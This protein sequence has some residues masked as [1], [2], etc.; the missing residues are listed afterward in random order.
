MWLLQLILLQGVRECAISTRT[1]CWLSNVRIRAKQLFI[2]GFVVPAKPAGRSSSRW[3][4]LQT[5]LPSRHLPAAD[6]VP[7]LLATST[8]PPKGQTLGPCMVDPPSATFQL[9]YLVAL[10]YAQQPVPIWAG[11]SQYHLTSTAF[12]FRSSPTINK[13]DLLLFWTTYLDVPT[14]L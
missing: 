6:G 14:L 2:C 12:A 11:L 3:H 10:K 4:L 8:A 5:N 7:Q 1:Q 9:G 13:A